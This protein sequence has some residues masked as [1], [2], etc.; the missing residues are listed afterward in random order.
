MFFRTSQ[1]SQYMMKILQN[2]N[3]GSIWVCEGGQDYE[4]AIPSRS[5]LRKIK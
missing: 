2:G 1:V 3:N 4:V 5:E